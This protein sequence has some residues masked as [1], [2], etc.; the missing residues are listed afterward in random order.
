MDKTSMTLGFLV[1]RQ[2]AGQRRAV[3]KTI[4]GYNYNGT[5]LPDINKVWEDKETY[6]Y[7]Y[8][9]TISSTTYLYFVDIPID[10]IYDKSGLRGIYSNHRS[11]KCIHFQLSQWSNELNQMVDP[12]WSLTKAY[13]SYVYSHMNKP[14]W[15]NADMERFDACYDA[16]GNKVYDENGNPVYEA[17]EKIGFP[18]SDPPIPVYE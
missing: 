13:D 11:A 8:I 18:K 5:V 17:T 2:I 15:A 16:S 10:V 14:L 9:T 6:P 3:K 7:A 4:I 1:G 12:Y